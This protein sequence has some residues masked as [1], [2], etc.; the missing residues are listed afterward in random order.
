MLVNLVLTHTTSLRAR[1]YFAMI[2]FNKIDPELE[3]YASPLVTF[4]IVV[5]I[6]CYVF[7]ISY[8]MPPS[9]LVI[10]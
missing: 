2:R 3:K 7:T 6:V 9:D 5:S 10:K 1:I 4:A 8:L